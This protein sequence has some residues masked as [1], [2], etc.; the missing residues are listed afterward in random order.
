MFTVG[1]VSFLN[2]SPLVD[3]IEEDGRVRLITDVPSRLLDALLDR[4]A[5]IALCPT[6]DY[7]TAGRELCVVPVGAIASEGTTLTVKVFSR[8]PIETIEHV[9]VDGD[10]RTSV[11]L[12]QVVMSELHG[13]RPRL[14]SFNHDPQLHEVAD[15]VDALLLIGDKVVVTEPDPRQFPYQFDLGEAWR[16]ITDLPFVFAAWMAPLGA[17]LDELPELLRERRVLNRPRIRE[18]VAR[19]ARETGWSEQ[20]AEHYLGS[21]LR[22][23]IGQRELE[24]MTVFWEHCR[25]L[26]LI[27]EIRPLRIYGE[28]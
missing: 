25:R 20:L 14:T 3:G 22:Y 11:A 8:Q 13:I 6:I 1:S 26:G 24:A 5:S 9:A 21:L 27:D 16:R 23:E 19:R 17:E 10:S 15:E 28:S 12:L 2:A 4:S 18:I 7:Q